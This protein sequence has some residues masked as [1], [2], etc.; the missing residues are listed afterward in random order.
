MNYL[1]LALDIILSV[2]GQ[3][4]LKYGINSLGELEGKDL[5]VK[6]ILNPF[7]WVG[8][9]LYGCG[10]LTW[11]AVLSKFDL[12]VA[13]PALSLG[14]ILVMFISWQ[15]LGETITVQ[16]IFGTLL[17]IGGVILMFVKS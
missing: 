3:F 13:Y 15:F 14:Y 6:A 8:M 5:I 10:M 11:F 16:K 12:S 4:F 7:V 9:A 1:I 17:I 2:T